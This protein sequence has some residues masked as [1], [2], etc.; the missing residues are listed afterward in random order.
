MNMDKMFKKLETSHILAGLAF[1]VLLWALM[2]YSN[3]KNTSNF[4]TSN[5]MPSIDKQVLNT[6]SS[7]LSTLPEFGLFQYCIFSPI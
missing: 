6:S 7:S 3:D 4:N 1:V 2:K 5:K